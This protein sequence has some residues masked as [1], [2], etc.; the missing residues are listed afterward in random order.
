MLLRLSP[1]NVSYVGIL[2]GEDGLRPTEPSAP[3]FHVTNTYTRRRSTVS[4]C[5]KSTA[6]MPRAWAVRNCFHVGPVPRGAGPIPASCRICHRGGSDLVAELDEFALHA[7]V[8]PAR[9]V[10]CHVDHELADRGCRG[11]PSGTPPAGVVPVAGDQPPVPG[12]QRRGGHR[13]DLTPPVPGD[14]FGQCREPQPVARLLA[15]PADLTAQHHVLVP[16]NQEF[17][18]LGHLTPGQ[19]HQAAQQTA[20]KQVDGRE[21]HSGMIPARQAV[22]ARSS[23]RAPTNSSRSQQTT[24]SATFL[25]G[26]I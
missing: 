8:P 23:N 19:H 6:R 15:D 9:I 3:G 14:Q 2:A 1:Q 20:H 16:Q 17:G 24:V 26:C 21:D 18:I 22:Q 7:P 25:K 12:E 10:G 4:A 5:T 11:R 13:E